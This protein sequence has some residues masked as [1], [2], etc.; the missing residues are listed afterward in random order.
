MSEYIFVDR[1]AEAEALARDWAGVERLAVDTEF[2]RERTF[3]A[4]LC[5]LQISD[6]E[7]IAC[8]D[9]LAL[10]GPGPFA[11][12][13]C[14]PAQKKVF[15]SARQDLETLNE[16]LGR[17]PGPVWDTQV[18]AALL[19]YP[20]QVG[21]TRL[22]GD[23]LGMSLPKD[24]ARTD[25]SRRPLSDEQL[26]YAAA[27]VKWLLPLADRLGAE[28]E[29]LGRFSWATEECAALCDSSLYAFDAE[30]A[31]R[32]VKGASQLTGAALAR[33]AALASWREHEAR[34]SNRPRRW[35]L[36]D[37]VLLALADPEPGGA[38]TD[39]ALDALPPAV[40]RKH[41]ATLAGL[42]EGTPAS[43]A[44]IY[45]LPERLDP[46][47]EKLVKKLMARVRELAEQHRVSAPLLATRKDLEA[48]LRGRRDLPLLAGWRRELAGE[49]LL[50]R[51]GQ[52]G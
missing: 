37:E 49:E 27:D 39:A 26:H 2:V 28:L 3:S 5:L 4:R 41:A 15:H 52:A 19:G 35:I 7:R 8:V 51:V 44:P 32:R 14:N 50:A 33:L 30:N 29:R 46:D 34:R 24:H 10:D 22:V 25:W 9:M 1:N 17:V 21:Y 6:G 18:A 12:L 47:Q 36:A 23:E 11:E 43:E 48:L 13:L 31:W 40:Q 16:H 38:A 42:L 45:A 20:D